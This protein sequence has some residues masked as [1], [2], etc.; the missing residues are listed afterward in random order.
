[1]V[2]ISVANPGDGVRKV[3]L[4]RKKMVAKGSH[5]DFIFVGPLYPVSGSATVSLI[6]FALPGKLS[7]SVVDFNY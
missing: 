5:T 1:M 3:A 2:P 6:N 7:T 4:K